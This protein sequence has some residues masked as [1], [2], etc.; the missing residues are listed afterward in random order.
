[1]ANNVRTLE[2]TDPVY[3]PKEQLNGFERLAMRFISDR[4]DLP[5]ARLALLLS[6]TVLPLGILLL[7]PGLFNWWLAALYLVL[8][9]GVFLG[10]YILMLHNTSHRSLFRPRYKWMRHFIPNVLGPFFGET[11]GTYYVHHIG[12]HHPEN[13]L[14][15]D[16]SSTMRFQ[17]DNIFHFLLYFLRFI[18]LIVPELARYF[19]KRRRFKLFR[20]LMIGEVG[21]WLLLAGLLYLEPLPALVVFVIPIMIARFGM[22]AGNW[23]QHAFID[24]ASPE[25]CYRNSITCIN[26]VYNRRCFNDGY[27]IGHHL[28]A[29]RHWTEMP[30]EF[31]N[32]LETYAREGA[33]VFE[34]V[35]FFVV[36]FFL[37][38]RNY[39]ALARHYVPLGTETPSTEQ[40]IALLRERTRRIDCSGFRRVRNAEPALARG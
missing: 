5:F 2:L 18:V 11:P 38:T 23:A 22:M 7:I 26:C 21:F 30:I 36:W 10:P 31:Q 25:N 4:R 37:M 12:M 15:D 6:C 14:P 35:D 3:H 13:N 29:N 1:M 19:W 40:I 20:Q 24:A 28:K 8:S 9:Q 17:R 33:I 27:H 39:K 16:L 34:G 32:N